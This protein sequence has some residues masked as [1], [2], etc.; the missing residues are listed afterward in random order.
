MSAG[1][2]THRR[3]VVWWLRAA[4][5]VLLT[6]V[7]G[8]WAAGAA[9][10]RNLMMSYPPPGEMIDIGGFKMHLHC[11]GSGEPAVILIAGLDDFSI[12]WSQVQPEVA[13]TARV[14]SYDRAGLGWSE[15]SP[16]PRTARQFAKELAPAR[17][18]GNK[19]VLRGRGG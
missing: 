2:S 8:T 7:A 12:S 10:K 18:P 16:Y 6:L 17:K 14:C 15:A 19:P 1:Q 11:M 13:G 5:L 4:V 9:A 3:G